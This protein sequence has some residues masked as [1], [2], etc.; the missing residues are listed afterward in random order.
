MRINLKAERIKKKMT[1]SQVAR[2]IHISERQYQRLEAGTS[3]GTIPIWGQL[4]KLLD[5]PI[6]FLLID[7]N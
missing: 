5:K 7:S 1:Q 2:K 4:E 3:N 6:D